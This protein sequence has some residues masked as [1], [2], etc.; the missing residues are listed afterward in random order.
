MAEASSRLND[1]LKKTEVAKDI[2]TLEEIRKE[3]DDLKKRADKL[4]K[5][6][7]KQMEELKV[8]IQTLHKEAS[9]NVRKQ[10]DYLMDGISKAKESIKENGGT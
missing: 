7:E 3:I 10:L 9:L 6:D 4:S 1:L 8:K 5:E 2:A